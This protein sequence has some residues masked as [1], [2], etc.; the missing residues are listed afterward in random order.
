[1]T[2][3]SLET[4]KKVVEEIGAENV[5]AVYS[6]VAATSGELLFAVFHKNTPIDIL[7]NPFL[8]DSRLLFQN[9]KWLEE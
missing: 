2:V 9:G 8:V 5:A 7:G 4:A 1:M 6:Y 3:H